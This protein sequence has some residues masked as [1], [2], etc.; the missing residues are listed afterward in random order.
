MKKTFITGG[1]GEAGS[2]LAELLIA[3]GCEGHCMVH[4]A[5]S[6]NSDRIGH[7]CMD[8]RIKHNLYSMAI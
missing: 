2:Y 7:L 8:D 3:K 1:A 4:R 6:F 5:S